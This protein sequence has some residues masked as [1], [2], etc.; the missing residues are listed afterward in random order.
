M[1]KTLSP[2]IIENKVIL[3]RLDLNVPLKDGHVLED[4]RI[5]ESLPTLHYLLKNKAQRIHILTHLGRPKGEIIPDLSAKHLIDELESKLG[6]AVE[7]RDDY[8]AGESRVQLHENT[9][10]RKEEKKGDQEAFAQ[11]ILDGTEAEIF[12]NDGFA[13]SHRAQTSVVGFAGKIPCYAGFLLQKEIE[14]LAPFLTD[15]KIPGLVLVSGGAKME[16]KVP[17]LKHFAKIAD[18]ILVGGALSNTFQVA[19]GYDVGESL[20][21]EDQV[22]TAREV[23]E[24]A[25]TFKTGFHM[26]IDV[27]CAD[28]PDSTETADLPI[29]DVSGDAKIFDIGPH[30]IA[31]FSEIL[32]YS[33]VIIWNGPLG[34][35]EKKPFARGTQAI[36]GVIGAQTNARTILGGGDT[37]EALRLFGLDK[38][39]FTHVSTGGGA[40]LEFLAGNEL[41]GI[42][43]LK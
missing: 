9:R 15:E 19:Q 3:I 10:F 24:I 8:S 28:T 7:F 18:H 33:N 23:L 41:P 35:M 27:I 37:I 30:S 32:Q 20:Y 38:S 11:E 29:E 21:Q 43:I 12:I 14:A 26:P 4:T 6:E 2:E 25:S 39:R 40:M 13:V 31:S 5:V 34:M 16:T 42:E 22:E 36:A 1:I 17:V